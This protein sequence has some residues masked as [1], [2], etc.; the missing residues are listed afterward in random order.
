MTGGGHQGDGGGSRS[1]PT[2]DECVRA[3]MYWFGRSDFAAA[4]AWWQ[5]AI[6][7]DPRS[8]RAHEC[9]RLLNKTSSTGFKSDA[10][11]PF[12]APSPAAPVP[13]VPAVEPH[14]AAPAAR[15]QDRPPGILEPRRA[16]ARGGSGVAGGPAASSRIPAVST[17]AFDFA[18]GARHAV[19]PAGEAPPPPGATRSPWDDGPSRTSVVTLHDSGGFDAVPEPTPLPNLDRDVFFGRAPESHDEIVSFLRATGDL[20]ME[21]PTPTPE[22][23]EPPLSRG[24]ADILFDDPVELDNAARALASPAGP[25]WG[26]EAFPLEDLDVVAEVEEEEEPTEA[27]V[28]PGR[29]PQEVLQE[30]R[31]RFGLHDFD[32]VLERLEDLPPELAQGEEARSLAAEA[33]RNLLKMYES[34]IGDFERAPRVL[35]SDEEVIWLNLNHRA[36]FILSQID[37]AVTYEDLV[38]LSGMPR[39]DTV[40]ILADLIDKKVVG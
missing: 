27:A 2:A 5:R 7:L 21:P 19:A 17:D 38:A 23:E 22:P 13:V 26:V 12:A 31:D 18:A 4:E 36:G 28:R 6:E 33:R 8:S 3:G 9:L 30:A 1:E 29:D 39:L 20:P 34:K 40:R 25:S 35:I 14:P 24:S 15:A 11:N 32:G 16:E 10:L 37:G